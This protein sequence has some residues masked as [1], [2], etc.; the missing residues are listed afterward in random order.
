MGNCI[1]PRKAWFAD[2]LNKNGREYLVFRPE[3]RDGVR[4]DL[5]RPLEIACGKC[6]SCLEA[7]GAA[8]SVRAYHDWSSH[9]EVG[10]FG[11]LTYSD[12]HLPGDGRLNRREAE[13]FIK[14]ADKFLRQ[15]GSRWRGILCGEYGKAT[16]RP[17]YHF[18]LMGFDF[19]EGAERIGESFLSEDLRKLWPQGH[20][21]VA[22]ITAGRA[23]YVGRHCVKNFHVPDAFRIMSRRPGIGYGWLDRFWADLLKGFVVVDGHK[24]AIPREYMA[25]EYL[26]E[27]LEPV[28]DKRRAYAEAQP[29]AD[30]FE[31]RPRRDAK[32]A[33][34]KARHRLFNGTL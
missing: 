6:V 13:L 5:S 10:C 12:D 14:R 4:A 8:L 22:P 27:Q 17:H 15:R 18:L 26:R 19:S 32:A 1:N 29:L 30:L 25:R 21:M 31:D 24:L 9:G 23:S 11:T 28:R 3:S 2:R 33:N 16:Y 7:K 34:I 20:S